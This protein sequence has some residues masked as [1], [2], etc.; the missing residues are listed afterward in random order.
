MATGFGSWSGGRIRP[1]WGATLPR[2]V[3]EG[4]CRNALCV[5]VTPKGPEPRVEGS[6]PQ[7]S[8]AAQ[9][10]TPGRGQEELRTT[11]GQ[12]HRSNPPRC[13]RCTSLCCLPAAPQSSAPSTSFLLPSTGMGDS[14]TRCVWEGLESEL[15]LDSVVKLAT[16]GR[17]DLS[18]SMAA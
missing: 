9:A 8:G 17:P 4:A 12:V 11:G 6:G 2:R 13:A 10:G 18:C 3:T 5:A 1:V 14:R 7:G 16:Q 15:I